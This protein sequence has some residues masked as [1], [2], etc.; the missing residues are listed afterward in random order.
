METIIITSAF[1]SFIVSLLVHWFTITQ[2]TKWFD[3]FFSEQNQI[4]EKYADD[5]KEI[6]NQ[7]KL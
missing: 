1:T 3:K 7:R 5:I 2:V 6:V 4:M